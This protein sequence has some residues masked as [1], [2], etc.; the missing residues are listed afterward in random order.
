[1]STAKTGAALEHLRWIKN[2]YLR[3][4][5]EL[6]ANEVLLRARM[7]LG[8]LAYAG[9]SKEPGWEA[10]RQEAIAEYKTLDAA[11][12]ERS[13]APCPEGVEPEPS[14]LMPCGRDSASVIWPD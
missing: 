8:S 5:D 3:D 4:A 6:L 10:M 9:G 7:T 11:L 14:A 2:V 1:M 13:E 12:T